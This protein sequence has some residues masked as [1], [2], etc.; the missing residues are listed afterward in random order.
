MPIPSLLAGNPQ[1]GTL[2]AIRALLAI[3]VLVVAERAAVAQAPPGGPERP[4]PPAPAPGLAPASTT[5]HPLDPLEPDEIRVPWPPIRA[6][7][8]LHDSVRFV[9][10]A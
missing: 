4:R 10:S 6:A 5:R 8:Q 3:A 9:S 2:M 1:P 7:R